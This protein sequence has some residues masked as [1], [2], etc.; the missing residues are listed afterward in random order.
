MKRPR[1]YRPRQSGVAYQIYKLLESA[2]EPM[3]ATEL[4]SVIGCSSKSISGIMSHATETGAVV[5]VIREGR[6]WYAIG[7]DV[8]PPSRVQT[9]ALV[10]DQS[11]PYGRPPRVSSVFE[12]GAIAVREEVNEKA[13]MPSGAKK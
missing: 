5:K 1:P 7:N 4:S 2:G 12:L 8:P 9:V 11:N 13:R 3:S 6:A 10:R